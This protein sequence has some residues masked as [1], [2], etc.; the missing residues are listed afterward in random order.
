M[1]TV[2]IQSILRWETLNVFTGDQGIEYWDQNQ[3][4]V[5]MIAKWSVT[6]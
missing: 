3:D 5:V 4:Q 6:V 1:A 2:V